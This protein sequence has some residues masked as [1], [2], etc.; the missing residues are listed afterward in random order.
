MKIDVLLMKGKRNKGDIITYVI[1]EQDDNLA[2]CSIIHF[3]AIA[4]ADNAFDSEKISKPEDIFRRATRAADGIRISLNKA[5]AY[6]TCNENLKRLGR[7]AGFS[8]NVTLYGLSRGVANVVNAYRARRAVRLPR[9]SLKGLV[10]LMYRSNEH[11]KGSTSTNG[12]QLQAVVRNHSSSESGGVTRSQKALSAELKSVYAKIKDGKGTELHN[13]YTLAS[14]E[15]ASEQDYLRRSTLEQLRSEYFNNVDT[16]EIDQQLFGLPSSTDKDQ[17]SEVIDFTFEARTRLAVQLFQGQ[18]GTARSSRVEVLK[19]LVNLCTLRETPRLRP[20]GE[21]SSLD[22]LNTVEPDLF[23]IVCPGTQCLFCLG[24]D[25][26]SHVSRT[27]LFSRVDCLRRHV[28]VQHL[29]YIAAEDY[30]SCLHP[31]WE[32]K[33]Q[34]DPVKTNTT[35]SQPWRESS[36]KE[37]SDETSSE[38]SEESLA[39][40]EPSTYDPNLSL[41]TATG[42]PTNTMATGHAHGIG[43]N[44]FY[45]PSPHLRARLKIPD[46]NPRATAMKKLMD[47]KQG[48]DD[49]QTYLMKVT[50][51]VND[52][53]IGA[54]GGK[55]IIQT[56][57]NQRSRTALVYST[58]RMTEKE[59]MAETIES[60]CERAGQIIRRIEN[61]SFDY[62][63]YA[64]LQSQRTYVNP[65]PRQYTQPGHPTHSNSGY[66]GAS[67]MDIGRVRGPLSNDEKARR[68]REGLC[69]Y[70][71]KAGHMARDCRAPGKKGQG[72]AP[73]RPQQINAITAGDDASR[74]EDV[75]GKDEGAA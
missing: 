60:F 62:P 55:A 65:G 46:P 43:T 53:D 44:N 56:H 69:L 41:E 57:M 9:S 29:K 50:P 52:S 66:Y 11:D 74:F 21:S 42:G 25:S 7:S 39:N 37:G 38:S 32:V 54:I 73:P 18:N 1:Y 61:E 26:L 6:D 23:L 15:L 22:E 70:C 34:G 45:V 5:L 40:Q 10:N 3:L 19:H 8:D 72:R 30:I 33:V 16:M 31:A 35:A 13:K 64:A 4:F 24:D 59:L 27:F 47:T 51:L 67:P 14:K 71:G 28:Q 17:E 12:S 48:A 75:T 36:P 58:V 20:Q 49:I 2:I 63:I 68:R